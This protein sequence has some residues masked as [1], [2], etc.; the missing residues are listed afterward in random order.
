MPA[1]TATPSARVPLLLARASTALM[2]AWALTQAVLAG[3]FLGG[4]YD[5]L[6]LH[7]LGAR[8]VTITSAVQIVI[9]AWVWRTTGRRG[10]F[11]AGAVQT[12]LLVAE[13]ATG[14]L[15]L[16]ALHVPL[17]VLL[18]VGIVQ[19]ATMIWRAPVPAGHARDD[20]EMT[21]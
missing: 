15:R 18:V 5:A 11:A 16:T 12:L 14:E 1:T 2:I 7:A 21:P 10:P 17:G 3:N 8:A 4:Q 9:L 20:A 19:L 13:F 6:R